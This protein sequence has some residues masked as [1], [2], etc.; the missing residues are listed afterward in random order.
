M[1]RQNIEFES[2]PEQWGFTIA[3][4]LMVIV[5]ISLVAGIGGGLYVGTYKRMLVEK[6]ARDFLLT[7][8]YARIMAIEQL[9]PYEIQLD[10]ANNGFWLA[11]SQWDEETEQAEQ[12]IVRDYYC[13]PVQFEGEVQFEDIQ[14]TP[15]GTEASTETEENQAIVF[16]PNGTAESAVI[17][18]GDGKNH[19]TISIYAAT[20]KAK[21]YFGTT[22]NIEVGTID[23]DAE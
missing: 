14:V 9:R 7:T 23:L 15:V 21:M 10:V 22:E 2:N 16:S 20:G 12:V 4:L 3:E 11:T 5:I 19:Y 13:K 18:I 17:Q 8:K 6:A 1:K